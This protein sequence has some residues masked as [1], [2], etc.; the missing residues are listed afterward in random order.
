MCW[1]R[2]MG[3]SSRGNP[4][5]R[6]QMPTGFPVDW[7]PPETCSP[8]G[9]K[10]ASKGLNQLPQT[11]AKVWNAHFL[12]PKTLFRNQTMPHN[13]EF[14]FWSIQLPPLYQEALYHSSAFAQSLALKEH[15]VK[16]VR[17][18]LVV[19][20]C[21]QTL[22]PAHA[23]TML[24]LHAHGKV[25]THKLQHMPRVGHHAAMR[26]GQVQGTGHTVGTLST[27]WAH[28]VWCFSSVKK[29]WRPRW[30]LIWQSARLIRIKICILSPE[31]M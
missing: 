3:W 2:G 25:A 8:Q 14:P 18:R 24:S 29:W 22:S 31:S 21:F 13:K 19:G 9:S 12:E 26:K 5:P 30:Q 1:L 28:G 16:S 23:N 17:G 11:K 6:L 10:W 27:Q 4:C 20:V 15:L 7:N